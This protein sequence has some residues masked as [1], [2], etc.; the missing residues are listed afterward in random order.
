MF[1]NADKVKLEAHDDLLKNIAFMT[2]TLYKLQNEINEKGVIEKFE[3]G[4]QN[5]LRENPA[6]K[7]YNSTIKNYKSAIK[8]LKS[9]QA[10]NLEWLKA[11][12]NKIDIISNRREQQTL[13]PIEKVVI[14][15][16]ITEEILLPTFANICGYNFDS[17]GINIY[18]FCLNIRIF[19]RHYVY[20]CRRFYAAKLQKQ[21]QSTKNT[22][23]ILYIN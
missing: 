9:S 1:K 19:I 5:F 3:Q 10:K 4:K 6:L 12:S 21:L 13:F 23:I 14:A 15:E 18:T 20:L 17:N 11:I 7:S 2:K 8:L 22:H 16:G